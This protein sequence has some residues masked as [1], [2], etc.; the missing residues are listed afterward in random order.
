MNYDKRFYRE[1]Q[2]VREPLKY[3]LDGSFYALIPIIYVL[4]MIFQYLF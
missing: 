1:Y 2:P 3:N 4:V